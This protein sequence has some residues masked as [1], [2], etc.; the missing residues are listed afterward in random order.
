MWRAFILFFVIF[1]WWRKAKKARE[2]RPWHI[3]TQSLFLSSCVIMDIGYSNEFSK[4]VPAALYIDVDESLPT[5]HG[6]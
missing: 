1:E 2:M 4:L 3:H 5:D 6:R